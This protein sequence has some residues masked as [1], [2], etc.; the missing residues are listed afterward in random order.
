MDREK[1]RQALS[2]AGRHRAIAEIGRQTG[3]KP[4]LLYV[5]LTRGHLGPEKAR[6]LERW[7]LDHGYAAE[8]SM[9]RWERV[10][11]ELEVVA[12]VL[13]SGEYDDADKARRLEDLKGNL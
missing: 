11:A 1:L 6:V 9:T 4:N 7:C 5:F 13:R 8:A 12:G 2:A 10:A 3:I